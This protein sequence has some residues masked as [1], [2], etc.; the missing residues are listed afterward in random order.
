MN[1]MAGNISEPT[2]GERSPSDYTND[3]KPENRGKKRTSC[4]ACGTKFYQ[5]DA[6]TVNGSGVKCPDCGE[7]AHDSRHLIGKGTAPGGF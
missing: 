7:D 5:E 3:A 4:F 6:E 1:V 2:A